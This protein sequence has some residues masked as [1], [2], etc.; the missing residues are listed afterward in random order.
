MNPENHKKPSWLKVKLP[1]GGEY[2]KVKK[3]V[4][5]NQLHTICSSG[6]CPNIGECWTKG[7]A[8]F[9]IAGEICTRKCKFCATKTGRPLPLDAQE[10]QKIARSVSLMQLKHCV[11]TSVDRDDLEDKGAKHWA[12]TIAEI[13]RQN[14]TT[15]IEILT[16][17]FDAEPHLLKQ[18]FDAEPDI[19]SHNLE[20]VERL[21]PQVRSKAQYSTSLKVLHLAHKAGLLTKSGIMVG[22]GE[23]E[24]E[25]VQLMHDLRKVGCSILTIGQYLQPTKENIPVKEYIRPETFLYYKQ[26]ALALG[27]TQV[28]SGALVRSSYMAEESFSSINKTTL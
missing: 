8:T 5:L 2:T 12:D 19:F 28:E 17:D 22:L 27:F 26:Q 23:E 16:P 24:K 18:V 14:P 4:E 3:I 20:T 25:V 15:I 10:P 11:I 21:S 1:Q 9:M 6:K 7:T 13:R